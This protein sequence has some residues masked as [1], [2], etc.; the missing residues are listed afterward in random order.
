MHIL[1]KPLLTKQKHLPKYFGIPNHT[2]RPALPMAAP[3][4]Y[5]DL[6]PSCFPKSFH[7]LYFNIDNFEKTPN[8]E[9]CFKHVEITEKK[10]QIVKIQVRSKTFHFTLQNDRYNNLT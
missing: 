9:A 8:V 7:S 3:I 1:K 6:F 4:I 10:I 5:L 2:L